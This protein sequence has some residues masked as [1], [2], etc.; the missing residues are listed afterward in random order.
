MDTEGFK[1]AM[2]KRIREAQQNGFREELYQF[3]CVMQNIKQAS[4]LIDHVHSSA[5]LLVEAI[6]EP[7][8]PLLTDTFTQEDLRAHNLIVNPDESLVEFEEVDPDKEALVLLSHDAPTVELRIPEHVHATLCS[9]KQEFLLIRS[10]NVTLWAKTLALTVG[11]G[12]VNCKHESVLES[13]KNAIVN[14]EQYA[15]CV[16]KGSTQVYAQHHSMAQLFDTSSFIGTDCARGVVMGEG[17]TVSMFGFSTIC[18]N[19]QPRRLTLSGNSIIFEDIEHPALMPKFNNTTRLK[20]VLLTDPRAMKRFLC[21]TI[22]PVRA[23]YCRMQL[24]DEKKVC[25]S[26]ANQLERPQLSNWLRDKI[27]ETQSEEQLASSICSVYLDL[28]AEGMHPDYLRFLFKE[29]TLINNGFYM[30]DHE[31]VPQFTTAM[32]Y[33][34]FGNNMVY[35]PLCSDAR[36]HFYEDTVG[37]IDSNTC[38]FHQNAIGIGRG[39][40]VL[41]GDGK[42]V[43]FGTENNRIEAGG[44]TLVHGYKNTTIAVKDQVMSVIT[45]HAQATVREQAAVYLVGPNTKAETY[46]EAVA[47][48]QN[49]SQ[50]VVHGQRMPEPLEK[51]VECAQYKEIIGRKSDPRPNASLKPYVAKSEAD[52]LEEAESQRSAKGLRM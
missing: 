14:L 42:A 47:F 6:G 12:V 40:S 39:D 4:H 23:R 43:L 25:N 36:G 34:V 37:V 45:D 17:V 18:L 11:S 44:N 49:V 16:A 46:E 28:F 50:V 3:Y 15:G 26:I 51:V 33:H 8:I 19:Q 27:K 9:Y 2:S 29:R 41:F 13:R 52:K 24:E 30:F 35:Q 22:N 1:Q 31:Y 10:G 21:R 20:H 5:E 38:F 32:D 48:T 7:I